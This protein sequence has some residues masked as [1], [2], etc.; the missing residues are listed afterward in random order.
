MPLLPKTKSSRPMPMEAPKSQLMNS[1][2]V[3]KRDRRFKTVSTIL[4]VLVA[5]QML[6]YITWVASSAFKTV[7]AAPISSSSNNASANDY[8]GVATAIAQGWLNDNAA[9]DLPLANGVDPTIGRNSTGPLNYTGLYFESADFKQ[10]PYPSG[11]TPTG[12]ILTSNANIVID[13]FLVTTSSAT[14]DLAIPLFIS[15]GA[16]TL[17]GLPSLEPAT[18]PNVSQAFQIASK[19]PSFSLSASDTTAINSWVNAF[20]KGDS[21]TLYLLSGDPNQDHYLGLSGWTENGSP[22]VNYS[23]SL[24]SNEAV[25]NVT[26]PIS[27]SGASST[28]STTSATTSAPIAS[29][30]YDLLLTNMNKAVPSIAAWGPSGSGPKLYPYENA[31]QGQTSSQG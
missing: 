13:H 8:Q 9:S 1:D 4:I 6:F 23:Y 10:V 27:P 12:K 25:V 5:V 7:K 30:S 11:K 19:Y 31:Q 26:L 20:V 2:L 14:Y 24:N 22:T 16:A 28:T 21:Q 18:I 17:Y 3:K 29:V 15:N